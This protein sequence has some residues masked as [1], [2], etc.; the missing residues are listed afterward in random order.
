[1]DTLPFYILL[2][3]HLTSLVVGFGSVLVVD[4]LGLAWIS[5]K[6]SLKILTQVT[7]HIQKLI[8]LGWFGLVGSGIGL[9]LIKGY[10]DELTQLKLFFVILVGANGIILHSIQK[11]LVTIKGENVPLSLKFRIAV[12]CMISQVGWWG[13]MSI[14]F[15]HRHWR[16][17]ISW[18]HDPW[19]YMFLIIFSFGIIT[20]L[21]QILLS[22]KEELRELRVSSK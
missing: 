19:I 1:M 7:N 6:I 9:I 4:F 18:P 8:W 2:F 11:T 17:N 14:G 5:S 3:I 22:S 12:A 21:G 16:H 13:A 15:L 10:I 20:V